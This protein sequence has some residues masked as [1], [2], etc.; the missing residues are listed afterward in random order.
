MN[1]YWVTSEVTP[2]QVFGEVKEETDLKIKIPDS[3]WSL[4]DL[5]LEHSLS[6]QPDTSSGH[7]LAHRNADTR[8]RESVPRS[9]HLQVSRARGRLRPIS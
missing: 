5:V 7:T 1:A 4:S 3:E 9:K 2:Q 6:L 8:E